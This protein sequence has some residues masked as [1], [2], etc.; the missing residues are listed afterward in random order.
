MDNT[1]QAVVVKDT[2][3]LS[4]V[5]L[6]QQV[7]LIQQVMEAVMV[8]PCKENPNGVHYGTIPGC[9]KKFTLLKPGAEKLMATFRI[10]CLPKIE[11]MSSPDEARYRI[12]AQMVARDGRIA[13]E[14]IGE[15]SSNESKYMW[16]AAVCNE[17]Y[18]E[19]SADRRREKWSKGWDGK[20][21]YKTKQIRMEIA[22]VANT[23]LKM[24]KK[25]ALID[26]VLTAT[27]AS[28]IFAQDLD[29]GYTP[30]DQPPKGKPTVQKPQAKAAAAAKPE[31]KPP[32]SEEEYRTDIMAMLKMLAS[33]DDQIPSLLLS[34]TEFKG[35]DG[36]MVSGKNNV[37]DL[38]GKRLQVTYGKI[39]KEY[40]E[41][42]GE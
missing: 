10:A 8:G 23:V 28:D 18:D 9:G 35:K 27:G 32:K 42:M 26:G 39:D 19:T 24:A 30:T 20:P 33:S 22:D 4:A 7:Q 36:T 12:T 37:N 25:R 3:T 11:D 41:A 40:K 29:D 34:Y 13:G 17:E 5:Q 15:C 1:D 16:R 2:P 14:G 6:K 31:A 21:N 38:S